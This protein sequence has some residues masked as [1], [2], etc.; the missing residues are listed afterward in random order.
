MTTPNLHGREACKTADPELF[1][2]EDIT[3]E[4]KRDVAVAKGICARCPVLARCREFALVNTDHGV[5][6]GMTAEERLKWRREN[7][8]KAIPRVIHGA[9]HRHDIHTRKTGAA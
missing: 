5:W 7:G 8:V 1:F 4:G 6:G 2:A 3:K 9:D